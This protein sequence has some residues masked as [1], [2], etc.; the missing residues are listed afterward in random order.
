MQ[1]NPS[2][3]SPPRSTSLQSVKSAPILPNKANNT[4][5]LEARDTNKNRM[6]FERALDR[7]GQ[8]DSFSRE[9]GGSLSRN[10]IDDRPERD[11]RGGNNQQSESED[12]TKD[13]P[14]G[15]DVLITGRTVLPAGIVAS[16]DPFVTSAVPLLSQE[17]IANLQRMAAAIAEIA[18]TGIDAKMTVEFGTLNGIADSAIFGRDARGG[19][20]IHLVGAPPNMT[21]TN[22]QML[23]SDLIQRLLKRKLDVS[24]VDFV[25]TEA[26]TEQAINQAGS[27]R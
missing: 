8:S 3:N 25:E 22:A 19:L 1:S 9:L 4:P 15:S 13:Q 26:L 21:P 5:P 23:R 18:K 2:Q 10:S 20:T 24:S 14:L 27:K 12:D 6:T 7:Q 11:T 16:F 17:Q